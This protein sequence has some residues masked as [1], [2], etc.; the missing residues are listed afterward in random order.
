MRGLCEQW[1][2]GAQAPSSTDHELT[3]NGNGNLNPTR[4]LRIR[5]TMRL[6]FNEETVGTNHRPSYSE[7][8]AQEMRDCHPPLRTEDT[9]RRKLLPIAPVSLATAQVL[10]VSGKVGLGLKVN[11][12]ESRATEK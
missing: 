10:K 5:T 4:T 11:R 9:A 12:Q 1:L 6:T 7:K 3:R 2:K 8:N